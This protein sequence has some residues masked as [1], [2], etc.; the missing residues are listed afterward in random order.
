M[1]FVLFCEGPTEKKA[2]PA[3]IKRWLDPRLNSRVGIKPVK[4]EG[5]RELVDDTPKK[6]RNYLDKP[7]V[8]GVVALLDLYGPTLYPNHLTRADE[9]FVWAKGKLEE[10]VG[11]P[12]FR[13]FFAVHE[14]EAW[15]LSDPEIFPRDMRSA[16][17]NLAQHP[18]AVDFDHP[19][20]VRLNDLYRRHK[21]RCYKKVTYGRELFDKLDPEVAYQKCPRLRE[22]LDEMQRLAVEVGL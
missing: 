1:K 16:L 12:K 10:A 8:I 14:T 4:F 6:A 15:L 5:W 22:L 11:H 13:Q 21:K 18:E 2:L 20:Y 7:D 19:P 3:F 17:R 9:R